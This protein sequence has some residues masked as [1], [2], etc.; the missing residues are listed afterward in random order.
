MK[1]SKLWM[2]LASFLIISLTACNNDD[3]DDKDPV[4][5]DKGSISGELTGT[6]A[7][8]NYRVTD[9]IIVPEGQTLTIEPGTVLI[10]DGDLI[11]Q[12]GAPEIA[13]FGQLIAEGTETNRI[14]MTVDDSRKGVENFDRGWW[15]G[16]QCYPSATKMVL[17]YCDIEYTGAP[18]GEPINPDQVLRNPGSTRYTI[19]CRNVEGD[20]IVEHCHFFGINDDLWRP[21]GGKISF[22]Y[23]LVEFQG[24]TGG[25]CINAKAGTV[26]VLAYNLILG[27][28]TNSL[29]TGGALTNIDIYNNTTVTSGYRRQEAGRGGSINVE[30]AARGRVYNNLQVNCRFGPRMVQGLD[31]ENTVF[32]YNYN[33]A[34]FQSLIDEFSP[35]E[36]IQELGANDVNSATPGDKDPMFVNYSVDYT[37][38]VLRAGLLPKLNIKGDQDFRLKAGSPAIGVGY[39]GFTP[40]QAPNGT[41]SPAPSAD[42]GCYPT[43]GSGNK[44]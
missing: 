44:F 42:M 24:G 10:F 37:E 28:A 30:D 2:L 35:T 18:A 38:E 25:D 31:L 29:K 8:G 23:N 36:G 41:T 26:G 33:Y 32:D 5:E 27:S 11:G 13:V 14:V 3:D 19:Q 1:L 39:T 6:L 7:K 40:V 12:Q 34:T 9:H 22:C 43:N 20:F 16:V 21:Q 15:G 4:N 17:R